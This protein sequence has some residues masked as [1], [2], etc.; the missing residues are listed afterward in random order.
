M[1]N[2]K[3]IE[4]TFVNAYLLSAGVD[5]VLID[6]GLAMHREKLEKE[7]NEAG[8]YPGKLKLVL[9]THGDMDHAGNAAWLKE[10]YGCRIALHEN[11]LGLVEKG[12][13]VKR[14][15]KSIGSRLFFIIRRLFR[16]KFSFEKFTP[17]IFLSDGMR[18]NESGLSGT[19]YHLPGHTSGSVC[20][21]TEDGNFFAGDIFTNRKRPE[22]ASLIENQED[23]NKSYAR[24]KTMDIKTVYPGHGKPFPMKEIIPQLLAVS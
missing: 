24:I 5:F 12:I 1:D 19:V 6:T 17:D 9:I 11:D 3:T 21:L 4:L 7:L 22:T 20:I 8:C 16:K 14:K 15:T 2:I 18:L 23:L 10:K 13:Q